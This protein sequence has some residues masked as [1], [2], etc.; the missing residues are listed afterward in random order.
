[1]F[2]LVTVKPTVPVWHTELRRSFSAEIPVLPT[3][4]LTR[5]SHTDRD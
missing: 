2:A 4:T 3:S 1:M 5:V